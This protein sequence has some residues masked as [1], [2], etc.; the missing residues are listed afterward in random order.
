[1]NTFY[2]HIG[3][4]PLGDITVTE[5]CGSITGLALG[6]SFPGE[7]RCTDL[8]KQCER[9]LREYFKG[10]R[11]CF[12]LPL[13]ME[14]TAF[15]HRVWQ[16]IAGIPYGETISYSDLAERIGSSGAARAAGS[17]CGANPIAIIVPCHRVI[18]KNSLGGYAYGAYAK[19]TLLKIEKLGNNY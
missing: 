11:R 4:T 17:A 13:H 14:G 9:E 7:Y 5:N 1:M 3:D 10:E 2:I 16:A 18:G 19:K 8:L 15:Q 6:K 12:E